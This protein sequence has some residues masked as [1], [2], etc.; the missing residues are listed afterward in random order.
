[1]SSKAK[2]IYH[3]FITALRTDCRN[4]AYDEQK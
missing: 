3:Y 1:M 2:S 4:P